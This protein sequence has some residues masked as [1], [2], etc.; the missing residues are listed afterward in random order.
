[1]RDCL[2]RIFSAETTATSALPLYYRG[3]RE[4]K[5]PVSTDARYQYENGYV[6][7]ER[8]SSEVSAGEP[9]IF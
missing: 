8:A 6:R 3:V 7:K 4:S 2:S 1:M 9:D 5:T